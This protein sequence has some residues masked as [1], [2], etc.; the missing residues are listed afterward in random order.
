MRKEER[1]RAIMDLLVSTGSAG[2]D[3]LATRFDVSKMTVHRDLDDLESSGLLRKIRGGATIEAGTQFESNFNFR[4]KQGVPAKLA[5]AR[6]ALKHVEP[7]MTVIINDG[8]TAAVLGEALRDIRPLTVI[9][10]NGAVLASLTGLTGINLMSL[11]GA[12]SKKY[13]GYFGKLTEDALG[14]IRVDLA[15]ISSP[16]ACGT[17]VFH[18]DETVTRTKRAMMVAAAHSILLINHTRMDA[19]ALHKLADLNEFTAI[20]TDAAPAEE[21]RSQLDAAGLHL[22]ISEPKES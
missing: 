13:N 12:Y 22:T 10:N 15:F 7:G 18:M 1:H 5:M 2:L 17:E 11:G 9:T 3:E 6:S 21:V 19:Q 16:A 8:S 14:C 4:A 20:I